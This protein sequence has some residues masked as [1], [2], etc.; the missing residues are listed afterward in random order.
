[1]RKN[2]FKGEIVCGIL[3]LSVNVTNSEAEQHNIFMH[4]FI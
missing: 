3:L 2:L 1:M 4:L